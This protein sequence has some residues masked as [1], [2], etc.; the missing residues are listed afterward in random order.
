MPTGPP[1]SITKAADPCISADAPVKASAACLHA[2]RTLE[3]ASADG[4]L[5]EALMSVF[6][7][8]SSAPVA[9]AAIGDRATAGLAVSSATE[10][11]AATTAA[12]ALPSTTATHLVDGAGAAA[13]ASAGDFVVLWSGYTQMSG[14]LL[15]PGS[16]T[17][18][19]FGTFHHDDLIGRCYGSKVF[20]RK[21]FGWT[22]MLH[23]SPEMITQSLVHRT[24]IIYHADIALL[25]TLLDARPGKVFVEAGTGSGS[26]SVSLA[27][28]LQPGGRLHTFEFH[29][30]RQRQAAEDFCRYGLEEVISSAHGDVCRNGFGEALDGAVDG[31]FLDLPMPWLAIGHVSRCLA[32]EGKVCTFSPCIEQIDKTAAELR[33]QRYLDIRMFETLAVNWGVKAETSSKRRRVSPASV[34]LESEVGGTSA[35]AP[36]S[37]LSYQMPMRGHT[38]YLMVATKAPSG[39]IEALV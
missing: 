11:S 6:S 39:E 25:L 30:D 28:A 38:G 35:A 8:V 20:P 10:A 13:V 17:T 36:N 26:V 18:N 34:E 1:M 14:V 22:A 21:G 3:T 29:A 19:K 33:R 12:L 5:R 32:E 24:Q 15:Q 37:W 4:R 23:P 31:V 16:T 7:E 27:R 9:S 2:L